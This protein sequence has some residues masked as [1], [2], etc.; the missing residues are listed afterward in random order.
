MM[1]IVRTH[2]GINTITGASSSSRP[3][4]NVYGARIT[5]MRVISVITAI[6]SVLYFY[7]IVYAERVPL[8]DDRFAYM[9]KF[10][11]VWMIDFAI[12][13]IYAIHASNLVGDIVSEVKYKYKYE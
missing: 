9:P 3:L 13:M 5:R 8:R 4:V 1:R 2:T 10:E 11:F 6:M 12:G 7:L